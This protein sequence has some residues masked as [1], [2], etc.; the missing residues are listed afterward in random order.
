ME[1]HKEEQSIAERVRAFNRFYMPSMHLLGNHYLGSEYSVPEAR[2]FFEIYENEGCT[3]QE[4]ARAM[5]LDKGYLS[6][7]LAKH[8]RD[9]YI[10]R[11]PSPEDGR[12]YRLFLTECGKQR[13]ETFIA[14]SNEEI[15]TILGNLTPKEEKKLRD[16]LDTITE[17]LGKERIRKK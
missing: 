12:A 2:I 5:E 4:I 15:Q 11:E 7:I 1:Q 17:I 16:A 13:A 9:G 10:R 6:R 3:A 8:V 14:M